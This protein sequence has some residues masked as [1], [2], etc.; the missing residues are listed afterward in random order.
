MKQYIQNIIKNIY[1]YKKHHHLEEPKLTVLLQKF[2]LVF[3]SVPPLSLITQ[4]YYSTTHEKTTTNFVSPP[5]VFMPNMNTA[6]HTQLDFPF[7]HPPEFQKQPHTQPSPHSKEGK[8]HC[9]ESRRRRDSQVLSGTSY[10]S[11]KS[12]MPP[13]APGDSGK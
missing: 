5:P 4:L 8:H 9:P 11:S 2:E 7:L 13:K 3:K 1:K 12:N 6:S 10:G